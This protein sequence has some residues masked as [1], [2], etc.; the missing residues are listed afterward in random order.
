MEEGRVTLMRVGIMKDID[1]DYC[2]YRF[3]I[4][5]VSELY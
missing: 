4:S 5:F 3:S 2:F 1:V